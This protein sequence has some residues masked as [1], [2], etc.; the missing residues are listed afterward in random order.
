MCNSFLWALFRI[1]QIIT[2]S[3][4]LS[5]LTQADIHAAIQRHQPG[6]WGDVDPEHREENDISLKKGL[7]LFSVYHSERRLK[8]WVIT[9]T[10][11][12]YT[13]VLLPQDF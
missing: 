7:R 2:T 13:T 9:E 6:D 12:S 1:G 8:F 3:A 11:R 10:D 5:N 4:A